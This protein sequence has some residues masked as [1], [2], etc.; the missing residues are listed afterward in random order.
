[1]RGF[2]VVAGEEKSCSLHQSPAYFFL[3]KE[4]ATPLPLPRA[5]F[6]GRSALRAF[7]RFRSAADS[8]TGRSSAAAQ[9]SIA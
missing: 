5:A 1:M 2:S 3:L 6:S 9:R 4:T 7:R 8:R